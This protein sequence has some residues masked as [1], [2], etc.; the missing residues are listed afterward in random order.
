MLIALQAEWIY[1]NNFQNGNNHK[2]WINLAGII[3]KLLK[4]VAGI[5]ENCQTLLHNSK[6]F[7]TFAAKNEITHCID[8]ILEPLPYKQKL[9]CS[10]YTISRVR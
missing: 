4:N 3:E 2:D 7:S 8:S 10:L 9:F 6:I 1:W 5:I